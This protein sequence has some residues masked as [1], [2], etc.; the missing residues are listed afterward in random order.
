MPR[1][2]LI[3]GANRNWLLAGA[4]LIAATGVGFTAAKLTSPKS[5]SATEATSAEGEAEGTD[6]AADGLVM[7]A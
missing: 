1:K 5:P 7:T 3:A 4:A 6:H 2:S